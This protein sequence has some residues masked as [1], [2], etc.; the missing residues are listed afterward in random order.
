MEIEGGTDEGERRGYLHNNLS[1][2]APPFLPTLDLYYF[3]PL[4]LLPTVGRRRSNFFY[5]AD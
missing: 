1:P 5:S 3:P 2:P 4:L